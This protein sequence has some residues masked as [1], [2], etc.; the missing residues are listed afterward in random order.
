[1]SVTFEDS[2]FTWSTNGAYAFMMAVREK[3]GV[4]GCGDEVADGAK[5]GSRTLLGV[6]VDEGD[7]VLHIFKVTLIKRSLQQNYVI[8]K[9]YFICHL[10][11][12]TSRTWT[13]EHCSSSFC[14]ATHFEFKIWKWRSYSCR[15]ILSAAK[16]YCTNFTLS[17]H[18]FVMQ[19]DERKHFTLIYHYWIWIWIAN[20]SEL[21]TLE[22]YCWSWIITA[23]N[24]Y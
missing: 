3:F 15:Y 6:I 16:L 11:S 18:D 4:G 22:L 13:W 14:R 7:I 1:M 21:N 17:A 20:G 5:D 9:T 23:T 8:H 10:H 12:W 24:I 19:D 2:F